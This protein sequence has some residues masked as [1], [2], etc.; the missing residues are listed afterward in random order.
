MRGVVGSLARRGVAATAHIVTTDSSGVVKV[1]EH[2]I[3]T[4]AVVMVAS[5]LL[6]FLALETMVS[7][8]RYPGLGPC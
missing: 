5:T 8:L 7:P 1:G 6:V 3:S 4:W 2:N